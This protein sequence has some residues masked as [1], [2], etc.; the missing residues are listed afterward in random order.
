MPSGIPQA[1]VDQRRKR[2][3]NSLYDFSKEVM[4]YPDVDEQPHREM[5]NFLQ[6]L[7]ETYKTD[8]E[9][10]KGLLLVPRGSLKTSI[11]TIALSL[12]ILARNPNARILLSSHTHENAKDYLQ[13]IKGEIE[14]NTAFRSLV[15]ADWKIGSR[16][17][18]ESAII[19]SG[20]T[21]ILQ[22]ASI[23]TAGVNKAK[24]GG[25]FDFIIND[26]L[27]SED[28]VDTEGLRN[29]VDRYVQTMYPILEPGGVLLI[30]GT[31]WHNDDV[32]Q[33]ILSRQEAFLIKNPNAKKEWITV[34]RS[35][36]NDDGS[37]YFPRKLTAEFL[38]QAQASMTDKLFSV[39]YLNKPMAPGT[40]YFPKA[41]WNF[42]DGRIDVIPFHTLVTET[43]SFPVRITLALDPA[44]AVTRRADYTGITVVATDNELNWW[45]L[46]AER[47]K[48]GP[49]YVVDMVVYFIQE[50]GIRLV[51]V[52]TMANQELY[53]HLLYDAKRARNLEFGIHEYKGG[54]NEK[55]EKRIERLQPMFKQRKV[56][57]RRGLTDLFHQ[58][59]DWPE[60][61]HED[62]LD[63]LA[64]HIEISSKPGD[65]WRELEELDMKDIEEHDI[66]NKAPQWL[67][68]S[69]GGFASPRRM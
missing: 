20:R 61:D 19:I 10:H 15:G 12:F 58:L 53:K 47:I 28:N 46:E 14:T 5:C 59:E 48:A 34:I 64:Q 43:K 29:R 49:S 18:S 22:N 65:V 11:G 6:A 68:P 42:F 30:I 62:L 35:C 39:W 60:T 3:L 63:S 25:H 21:Q 44:Y 23:D 4:G 56:Y 8:T 50:Y 17:W 32:Y 36:Y 54:G 1:L 38:R 26:D 31:H 24:T 2:L 51:S 7:V 45:I 57:L 41:W 40:Q 52:D 66:G 37:L 67:D 33:R 16:E 13:K 27:H 9:Q 69:A 55:K